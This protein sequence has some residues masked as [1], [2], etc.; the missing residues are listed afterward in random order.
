MRVALGAYTALVLVVTMWPSPVDAGAGAAIAELLRRLHEAGLPAWFGYDQLESTANVL[1]FAPLGA[2]LV[3]AL[4]P[5]AWWLALLL[6]PALS[7]GI[8]TVQLLLPQRVP[9][10]ADVVANSLGSW[11][12]CGI[13]V[14]MRASRS[15]RARLGR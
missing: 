7:A 2:L 3:F 4:P 9:T 1:M 14:A 8:E 6:G 5:K 12:G 15:R 13:A 10:V 11:I